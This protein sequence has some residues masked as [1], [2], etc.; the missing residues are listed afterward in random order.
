MKHHFKKHQVSVYSSGD[1]VYVKSRTQKDYNKA[2]PRFERGKVIATKPNAF[3][4][5]IRFSSGVSRWI[6][7]KNIAT[8]S[9][10]EEL[11]K[12]QKRYQLKFNPMCECIS[13]ECSG[14]RTPTQNP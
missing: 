14:N 10:S 4:Y 13:D 1:D 6:N 11:L 12:R 3:S 9:R 7:V 8:I 2:K 5:K